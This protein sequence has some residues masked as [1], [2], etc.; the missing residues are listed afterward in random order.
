LH[1]CLEQLGFWC[2]YKVPNYHASNW[3]M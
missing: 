1:Y 2:T 3:S